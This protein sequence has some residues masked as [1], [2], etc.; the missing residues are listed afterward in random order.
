MEA[1]Y[2]CSRTD[3]FL[4]LAALETMAE[5]LFRTGQFLHLAV[6]ETMAE[7]LFRMGQFLPL[8]ALE[9]TAET[10]SSFS[11]EKQAYSGL[12]ATHDEV[13]VWV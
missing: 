5:I 9:T 8:A 11:L 3:Q 7:I 12:Q 4:R 10:W 1:A 2:N 13:G 6:L